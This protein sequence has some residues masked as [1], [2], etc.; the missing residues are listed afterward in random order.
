MEGVGVIAFDPRGQYQEIRAMRKDVDKRLGASSFVDM[1]RP[2][3][4]RVRC[5][6]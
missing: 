2:C 6:G 5:Y 1:M 4:D 3:L